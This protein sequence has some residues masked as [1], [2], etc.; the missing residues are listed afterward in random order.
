MTGKK[1][2]HPLQP[3]FKDKN[4]TLRFKPNRIIEYLFETRKLDL[5]ELSKMDFPDEDREQI[6][7]LLGYSLNGFGEL[8]YVTDDTYYAAEK[9]AE[10]IIADGE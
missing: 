1:L 3:M 7:Q 5:N 4:G 2:K 10:Q 9:I 8:S 6:A